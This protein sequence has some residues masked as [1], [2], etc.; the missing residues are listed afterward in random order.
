M[1][2]V[3]F[4]FKL[5]NVDWYNSLKCIVVSIFFNLFDGI[6][7]RLWYGNWKK[8]WILGF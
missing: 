1:Y 8:K 3:Y 7:V 5:G 4:G 2:L 6:F